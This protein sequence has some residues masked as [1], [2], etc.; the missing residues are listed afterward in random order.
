MQSSFGNI[1]VA[2]KKTYRYLNKDGSTN[3]LHKPKSRK[4]SDLYHQ[5]LSMSNFRFFAIIVFMYFSINFLFAL[6]YFGIGPSGLNG[7]KTNQYDIHL[8]TECFFFSIQ[9]FSTIGYGQIS[10]ASFLDNIVVS[11]QALIGLLSVGLM[12]GLFYARFSRATARVA[13]SEVA[14]ITEHE[15]QKVLTF[16]M[17][18][19]R[20]NQIIEAQ[21]SVMLA[22]DITTIEGN[23]I[24]KLT[25]LTLLRN[26]TPAFSLSWTVFHLIDEKSPLHKMTLEELRESHSEIFV[27]V[28]GH[29]DI[30]NQLIHSRFSYTADDIV[31]GKQFVDILKRNDDGKV[32]VEVEN[33][34]S[35]K[36]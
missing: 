29:D 27:I 26:K 12:S 5:L 9:T 15:G 35:L 14:L 10:P 18:N 2:L 21:I 22:K 1:S 11:I 36:N 20:M 6:V 24:R 25:D 28:S 23:K 30:F 19:S 34:S 16:R 8:F 32:T 17:A 33:I 7:L 4:L 13:F 31:L 3:I